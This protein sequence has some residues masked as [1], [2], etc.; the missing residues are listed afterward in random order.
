M[1]HFSGGVSLEAVTNVFFGVSGSY[2][3]GSYQSD[4]EFSATNTLNIYPDSLRTDPNDPRTAGFKDAHIGISA[5]PSTEGWD[6]RF[7]LIYR[8]WNFIGI[9]AS[10]K[11]PI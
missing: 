2:N 3:M 7:G 4:G 9:S 10:F 5:I 8:L 6:V 11:V 1:L